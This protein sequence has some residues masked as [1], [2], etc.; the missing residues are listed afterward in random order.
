MHEIKDLLFMN[1]STIKSFRTKKIR[2]VW[3]EEE[4]EYYFSIVDIV[5]VKC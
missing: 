3:N 1:K 4:K 2:I 5:S